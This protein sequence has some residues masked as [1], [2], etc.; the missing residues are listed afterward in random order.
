MS[1][2]LSMTGYAAAHGET[3]LG[4]VTIELRSVNSRFLDLI[5]RVP[6]EL[7][8]AEPALRE[9]LRNSVRR[10]KL[11]CRIGLKTDPSVAGNQANP[12]AL[13]TLQS[14]QEQILDVLPDAEKLSVINILEYPGVL[15]SPEINEEKVNEQITAVLHAALDAFQASRTR[16]GKALS[17]V[18]LGYCDTIQSV[19]EQLKPQLPL[20]L[21]SIQDKMKER[22][23]EA[24]E[25]PLSSASGLS[26][27]EI[28]D[29]IQTE[30]TLYALKMDV[31]EEMNR[32]LTHVSEVRRILKTGGAVGRKLDFL[33]QELNREANTLG[34]KA[35]AIEMTNVSLALKLTIEQM[36]EQIQNLE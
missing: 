33:M 17:A 18:L 12:E 32:L 11:E 10:G 16:E 35:S 4:L 21:T 26:R 34:S 36:R 7:R 19:V 8:S 27:E 13:K 24:L 22:L 2:V 1:D 25:G 23:K 9:I 30:L 3:A 20:I 5:L 29:R 14:L 15:S 28:N 31:D 6:D